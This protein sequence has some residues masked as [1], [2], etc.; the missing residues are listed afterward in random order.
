M[1]TSKASQTCN[2][3]GIFLRLHPRQRHDTVHHILE[4]LLVLI[5]RVSGSLGALD[6]LSVVPLDLK[7]RQNDARVEA[8]DVL[9]RIRGQAFQ[10]A[11]DCEKLIDVVAG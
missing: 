11:D 6:L 3:S 8:V 5:R 1:A 4:R 2:G 7:R 9:A 10:G